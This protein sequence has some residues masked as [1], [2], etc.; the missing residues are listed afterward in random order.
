MNNYLGQFGIWLYQF[1]L[2]SIFL[3]LSLSFF[4]SLCLSFFLSLSLSLKL[5][6]SPS[7]MSC[8]YPCRLIKMCCVSRKNISDVISDVIIDSIQQ[9]QQQQQQQ[10]YMCTNIYIYTWTRSICSINCFLSL[11]VVSVWSLTLSVS[12]SPFLPARCSACSPPSPSPF[13]LCFNNNH[14]H[15]HHHH[16]HQMIESVIGF[17]PLTIPF[18]ANKYKYIYIYIYIHTLIFIDREEERQ[19]ESKRNPKN[20]QENPFSKNNIKIIYINIHIYI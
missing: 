2:I 15:H 20:W 8:A 7:T 11:Y 10:I 19:R 9:Q 12:V 16:H 18:L 5:N 13:F 4:L 14:H 3:S 6:D 1:E 17:I